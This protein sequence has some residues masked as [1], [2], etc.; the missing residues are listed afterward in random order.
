MFP[1]EQEFGLE[2]LK[3]KCGSSPARIF[4]F[5]MYTRGHSYIAKTLRDRDFWN[6]LN[7]IS[8]PNWPIFAVRPLEEGDY[9]MPEP[10][11]PGTFQMMVPIW[12]EPNANRKYLDVFSLKES[13]DLPCLVAFIW[14]DDDEI[15]QIT[16]K[17]S[18]RNLEEAFDSIREVVRI[19]ADAEQQILPLYKRSI[20]VFR[21]VK[22]D[23]KA[24]LVRKKLRRNFKYFSYIYDFVSGFRG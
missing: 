2:E 11:I 10:T 5:V 7:E 6:E 17:L 18:N 9:K 21:N 8:G 12:T 22:E 19:I 24:H 13:R 1:L 4:G 20:T 15:E 3:R 14:N 23:I 16:C